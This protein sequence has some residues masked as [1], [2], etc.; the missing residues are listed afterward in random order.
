MVSTVLPSG[1][2]DTQCGFKLFTRKAARH[3]FEVQRIDGFSFDLEVLYLAAK[4]DYRVA[5]VP[6]EWYDAPGSKVDTMK[7]V[8]RFVRDMLHIRL[9]DLRGRYNQRAPSALRVGIVTTYPP[10]RGSLNEYGYHFVRHLR[11]KPEISDVVLLL[12]ELPPAETYTADTGGAPL[13]GI[14]CWRFG[15]WRNPLRI[16]AAVWRTRPDVVLFNI[17]FASF[18]SQRIAASLGLLTP[19][20]VKAAGFPTIVLL[21]NIMETV[22]LHQAGFGSSALLERLTRAAGQAI[23]RML[24]R[25]DMVALTVP[26]YVDILERTYRAQNVWLAPHGSFEDGALQPQLPAQAAQQIMTFGKF[27]TYKKVEPLIDAFRELRSNGHSDVELVIAGTDSPNTPGYLDSVRTIYGDTEGLH[28]TGYV[29][30]EDVPHVFGAASVVVFPYTATTGS[31]GVLHQAGSYGKAVVLPNLGDLAEM[32]SEEGYAGAFF[33]PDD[34]HSLKHAIAHVLDD[35]AY[36]HELE[37]R[38][39]LAAHGLP[40]QDVIDWYLLHMQLLIS[41]RREA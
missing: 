14:T 19:A 13:R 15:A 33:E 9:T 28:F 39:F 27:G 37:T 38:N 10:G 17:Q 16:L 24:L 23:T 32:V 21:H 40:M 30:E 6:V 11:Q 25:A 18:G 26:K 3:L 5:E 1:V 20:L 36:R 35:D 12:D 31:S 29:P 22:D 2:Q 7:E 8:R 34:A 41:E 4:Y